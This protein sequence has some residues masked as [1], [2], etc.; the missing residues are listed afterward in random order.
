MTIG[1]VLIMTKPLYEHEVYNKLLKLSEIIELY[2]LFGKYDLLAK[3][4]AD[5]Y[6]KLGHIVVNK[7]RAIDHVIDTNILTGS[8]LL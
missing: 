4:E 3:I 1:F 6:D 5:D 2:P 7:I 8:K